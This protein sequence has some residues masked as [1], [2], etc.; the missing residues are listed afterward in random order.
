MKRISKAIVAL[1]TMAFCAC[2]SAEGDELSG[3]NLN[4]PVS[5]SLR[6]DGSSCDG[7]E[8]NRPLCIRDGDEHMWTCEEQED[9][10]ARPSKTSCLPSQGVPRVC[11]SQRS[12]V[13]ASCEFITDVLRSDDGIEPGS[14]WWNYAKENGVP[15]FGEPIKVE[16]GS[17]CCKICSSGRACGDSCISSSKS[18]NT[19]GGCACNG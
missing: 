18:C 4:S 2:S 3:W 9:G 6:F 5:I 11:M 10:L 1:T 16:P 17:G 7:I 14:D 8:V 12:T 15:T 19:R 13:P